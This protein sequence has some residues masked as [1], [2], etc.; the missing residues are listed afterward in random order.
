MTFFAAIKDFAPKP[1]VD[2]KIKKK[3][4]LRL[5]MWFCKDLIYEILSLYVICFDPRNL[6]KLT[7]D[8]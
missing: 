1:D 5:I 3:H 4:I 2:F 6:L 8:I 7:E